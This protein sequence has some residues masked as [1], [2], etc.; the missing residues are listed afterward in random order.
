MA[1]IEHVTMARRSDGTASA[2]LSEPMRELLRQAA[3]NDPAFRTGAK[4]VMKM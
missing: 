4:P 3:E 2:A 1:V